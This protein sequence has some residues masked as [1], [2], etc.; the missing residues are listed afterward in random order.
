[1]YLTYFIIVLLFFFDQG[2]VVKVW[3]AEGW[4]EWMQ[5]MLKRLGVNVKIQTNSVE[6]A[7]S[8]TPV[9]ACARHTHL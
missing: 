8:P 2:F 9:E 6:R 4:M 7:L 1:M 3:V 5:K